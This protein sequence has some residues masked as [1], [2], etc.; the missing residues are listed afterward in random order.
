MHVEPWTAKRVPWARI[1]RDL[2]Y[3][4]IEEKVQRRKSIED[5]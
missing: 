3:I 4:D 5:K 2:E 1:L